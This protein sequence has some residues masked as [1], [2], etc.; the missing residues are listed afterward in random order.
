MIYRSDDLQ[1]ESVTEIC[2]GC[3]LPI[4]VKNLVYD[5]E[6]Y[7]HHKCFVCG[8]CNSSLVNSKYYDKNGSLF[9]NNCFLAEH[10]PTCFRCRV[11]IKGKG[12][13]HSFWRPWAKRF[14]F[15]L[16]FFRRCQDAL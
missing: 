10:L 4:H 12:M 9:C 16:Y 1:A 2:K 13:G 3:E 14:D 8:Q 5:G 6:S 7:W 11:E 15:Y